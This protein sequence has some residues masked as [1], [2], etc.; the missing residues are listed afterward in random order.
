[1][2]MHYGIVMGKYE[3]SYI[4]LTV[5][6]V[7]KCLLPRSI[8]VGIRE[9]LRKQITRVFQFRL[10]YANMTT[11]IQISTHRMLPSFPKRETPLS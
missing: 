11:P 10:E 5:R 3:D 8:V 4:I 9:Q 6:T 2:G 7:L 1:M